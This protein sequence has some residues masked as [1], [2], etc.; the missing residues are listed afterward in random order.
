M[1]VLVCGTAAAEAWPALFCSCEPCAE[2]R[3]RG[4]KNIR[5]RTGYM[6][7]DTVRIDFGPDTIHHSYQHNLAYEKLR[8]LL[9]SHSHA[10]HWTP[11]E[12]G[13]RKP[14]F[15]LVP[16]GDLLHIYGNEKVLKK[17]DDAIGGRWEQLRMKAVPIE[18]FQTVTLEPGMTATPLLAAHDPN[19]VCV[20]WMV[21]TNGATFVQGHDTGWWPDETWE[22]LAGRKVNVVVMDCTYGEEDQERGH[23]GCAAVARAKAKL[24]AS[25]AL[26]DDCRFIATHFSH[27]GHWLHEQLEA[28][29]APHGIEVAYDGMRLPLG[30]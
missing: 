16:E 20:N 10:D 21:E 5:S 22:Y 9:V 28:F 26:A 8:R 1:E 19:E 24:E 14:G 27:N 2:A 23:L 17:T 29:F 7:G 30:A 4:G 18:P 6:I 12:L 15:S 13:Y 3:R 11:G 25:G